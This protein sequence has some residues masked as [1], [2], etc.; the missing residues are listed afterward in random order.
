MFLNEPLNLSHDLEL[1][2]DLVEIDSQSKNQMGVRNI[3]RIIAERIAYLGFTIEQESNSE[4]APLLIA[5]L[6]GKKNNPTIALI[7]HS[8]TVI[9]QRLSPFRIQGQRALGAGIADNKAGIFIAMRAVEYFLGMV[10]ENNLNLIF[11]NSPTEEIGSPGFHD[12]FKHLGQKC[13]YAFGFE[14]SLEDGS[15]IHARNGNKWIHINIKGKAFHAG[16]AH[17]GHINAAHDLCYLITHL[18]QRFSH[19]PDVTFNI[20]EIKGGHSYNTICEEVSVKI[21]TRFQ[22]LSGL[23]H[24]QQV[25]EEDLS[26]FFAECCQSGIK[27]E[28][29]IRIDDFCP[30]MAGNPNSGVI[31]SYLDQIEKL[32]G[33]RP[34]TVHCGGAADINHFW[35]H[36]LL[37]L[38]GCGAIGGNLHRIDEYVEI[39]SLNTR[40]EA[41]TQFLL[42]LNQ[43]VS[44][45]SH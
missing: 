35:N 20:G 17:K 1:L 39:D 41:F 38:D 4:S 11:V 3:Q 12:Y 9:P 30:P 5:T 42:N 15:L 43:K 28:Y 18:T 37:G 25:L 23:S 7:N 2:A 16:R 40:A 44:Y 33:T 10:D 6:S 13:D 24:I 26:I 36:Q 8:D 19:L 34:E 45:A 29:Q 14:P 27:S 22:T 32:E 21:D 31:Q